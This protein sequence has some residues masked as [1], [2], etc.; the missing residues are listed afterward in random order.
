MSFLFGGGG[1]TSNPVAQSEVVQSATTE[2][3]MIT[4]LF[5]GRFSA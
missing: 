4:D 3:E 2:I 1:A 5:V